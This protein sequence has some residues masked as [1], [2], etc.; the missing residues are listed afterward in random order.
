MTYAGYKPLSGI[1]RVHVYIQL[2][3]FHGQNMLHSRQGYH[4]KLCNVGQN[5]NTKPDLNEIFDAYTYNNLI[6]YLINPPPTALPS[7][8]SRRHANRV[9]FLVGMFT[10]IF[11]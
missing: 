8:R 2:T 11:T 6:M 10:E 3:L 5:R 4:V 1:L 7:V 9:S